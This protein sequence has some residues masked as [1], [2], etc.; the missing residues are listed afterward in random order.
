MV[1][2]YV[3]IGGD[4]RKGKC[5][6]K[7]VTNVRQEREDGFAFEGR[8]LREGEH[9]L[10]VG[11]VVLVVEER[12]SWKHHKSVALVYQVTENGLEEKGKYYFRTEFVSLRD[13]II[14]LLNQKPNPLACFSVDE[15]VAELKRRGYEIQV[16][17]LSKEEAK[18]IL[19]EVNKIRK[20]LKEIDL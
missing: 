5:Y 14:E 8:F 11:A 20:E 13:K 2:V 3:K 17:N 19:E 6:A 4:P 18:M 10:P 7:L 12:G 1:K 16:R 15:L 9:D